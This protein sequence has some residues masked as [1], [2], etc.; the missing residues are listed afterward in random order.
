[1]VIDDD[2]CGVN[3]LANI[4]RAHF[5]QDYLLMTIKWNRMEIGERGMFIK[6]SRSI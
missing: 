6:T 4:N 3:H 1:M 5:M 2:F